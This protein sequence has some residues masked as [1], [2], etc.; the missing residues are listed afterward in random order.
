M[1]SQGELS[2]AKHVDARG[3]YVS[4]WLRGQFSSQSLISG[5]P[6]SVLEQQGHPTQQTA[7]CPF[8]VMRTGE[9]ITKTSSSRLDQVN[10]TGAPSARIT[11]LARF[12]TDRVFNRL[13]DYP[14]RDC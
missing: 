5:C 12:I 2:R 9:R 6:L 4:A 14:E 1:F 10:E 3:N 7:S 8:S 13:L 11:S